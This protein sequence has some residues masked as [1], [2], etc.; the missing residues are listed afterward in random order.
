[1]ALSPLYI[2]NIGKRYIFN[3]KVSWRNYGRGKSG[4]DHISL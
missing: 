2:K 3:E 1:M 4:G